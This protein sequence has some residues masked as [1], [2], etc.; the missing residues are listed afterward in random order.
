MLDPARPDELDRFNVDFDVM[1]KQ[2]EGTALVVMTY[3]Y[4]FDYIEEA[5]TN[6]E[7]QGDVLKTWKTN[8]LENINSLMSSMN[9]VNSYIERHSDVLQ[10]NVWAE[11]KVS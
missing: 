7:N 1:I 9:T 5:Y 2:T 4:P 6:L 10:L 3:L 11:R 8:I